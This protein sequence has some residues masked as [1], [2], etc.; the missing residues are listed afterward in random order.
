[1]RAPVA[2]AATRTV[3]SGGLPAGR[4]GGGGR[5]RAVTLVSRRV[6]PKVTGRFDATGGDG[7]PYSQPAG[8]PISQAP[9]RPRLIRVAKTL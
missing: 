6:L 4:T 7:I 8:K 3:T 1:L 2:A 9:R 5:P